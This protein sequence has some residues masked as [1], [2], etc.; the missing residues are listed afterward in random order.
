[1]PVPLPGDDEKTPPQVF[2]FEKFGGINTQARRPAIEDQQFSW[3]ENWMPVGN[4]N[5]RTLYDSGS[6]L[7]TAPGMRTILYNFPFNLGSTSYI[8]VFFDDG[9]AIAVNI[10]SSATTT[11]GAA[12]TFYTG[13]PLPACAQ[14]QSIYLLIVSQLGYWIWDGTSLFGAGTLGPVITVTDGGTGY[15]SAPTVIFIG[16][17]GSG[18]TAVA[19]VA[20]GSVVSVV[21]TNPGSGYLPGDVVQIAFSGGGGNDTATATATVDP[22]SQGISSVVVLSGGSGYSSD[23]SVAF[24][25]GGALEQA[26]AVVVGTGGIITGIII[27]NPGVGYTSQPTFVFT[28]TSGSGAAA[29]AVFSTGQV[30]GFVVTNPGSGFTGTPVVTITGDG[31]G[32]AAQAI[33]GA[34]TS[35]TITN[36]GTGL[37]AGGFGTV[38]GTG[39]GASVAYTANGAGHLTAVFPNP[40]SPIGWG[41]GYTGT[42][43]VTLDSGSGYAVTANIAALALSVMD[44]GLGYTFANVVITG[45]G[46]AQATAT[47]MPFGLT[48]ST[49]ETYQSRVWIANNTNVSFTAASSPIQFATSDGGGSYQATD[50]FLRDRVVRLSQANG[51]L[52]QFGDSS[53]N[54][55]SN[56][57]SVATGTTASTTFNNSNVDPQVGTPWRDTVVPF[58][59]ALVFANSSGVYALYGGAAEK[60]SSPLDGLFEAATF[61]TGAVGG[62]EPTAAVATIFG[63]RVYMLCFTTVDTYSKAQRTIL[64]MWDGQKWFIGTQSKTP[65]FMSTQEIDSVLTA[66]AVNASSGN[67]LYPVFKVASTALSKVYQTKLRPDPTCIEYKQANR[68][69]V[70]ADNHSGSSETLT[71]SID[72]EAGVGSVTT[73]FV[74]T[75]STSSWALVGTASA[76]YGRLLGLTAVTTGADLTVVSNTLL[77]REYAPFA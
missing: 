8:A 37:A 75:S 68:L 69:Y 44:G 77:W 31:Q 43:T 65:I 9:S 6:T 32:A 19:T 66:W 35:Y 3:I 33:T 41:T 74:L 58:G 39:T 48:G 55:I 15:T 73:G 12:N 11:I 21:V 45:N 38:S 14:W 52:Y 25:G 56:V 70:L 40:N 16:G 49:V 22:A 76:V 72:T 29:Q 67:K 4:G 47:L 36:V 17:S 23:V 71:I 28:A 64:A 50:S 51:F 53:I 5:L 1:M 18:A 27:T 26:T 59:R 10:A 24:T 62:V 63:I 61:N 60:V 7:Y 42:P 2:T 13:G 34:I 30:T 57:Q 46:A 54:V 20:G